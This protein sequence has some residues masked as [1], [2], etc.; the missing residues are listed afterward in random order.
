[1]SPYK[2]CPFCGGEPSESE[3]TQDG[4]PWKYIEC[5]DCAAMA[6]PDVWNR[7]VEEK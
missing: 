5:V 1:M 3:G 6:E 2:L 4:K 7:R